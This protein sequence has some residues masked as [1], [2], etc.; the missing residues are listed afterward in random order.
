MGKPLGFGDRVRAQLRLLGYWKNGK[1]D[2]NRFS[3]EHGY[4]PSYVYRW[5]KG[6]VPRGVALLRFARDLHAS[7][8]S[9]LGLEPALTRRQHVHHPIAGGSGEAGTVS[10]VEL[11]EKITPYL[12][13]R[14]WLATWWA[15]PLQP[16]WA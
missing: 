3:V 11:A 12:T 6:E 5:A 4:I 2:I 13:F 9:L 8:E 14:D 7:P 15:P 10:V 1:P 16:Q